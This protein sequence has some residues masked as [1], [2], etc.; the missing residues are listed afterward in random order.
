[1]E[2]EQQNNRLSNERIFTTSRVWE[3][4]KELW[5]LAGP[6]IV[7][8]VSQY[9]LE[10][11]TAAYVGHLGTLELAAVSIVQNVIKGFVYGL[12]LGMGSALETLCGQAVGAGQFNMLGIYMQRSWIITLTTALLLTPVY[13]FTSPILKLLRQDKHISELAGK[14]A[15][16]SIP[17][18]FG[19]ALNF[20]I[21]KFLQSQS[22][23][24]VTTI[25]L[26]SVLGVHAL[27][28]WVVVMRFSH[29]LLGAAM[30]GNLSWFLLIFGQLI[31]IMSGFFPGSWTGFSLLAFS[32]KSF[33]K[34]TLA[35]AIM[36]CLELWYFTIIILMVGWLK[37]PEVAVDAVSTCMNLDVWTLMIALGFNAAVSVRVSNE[38]GAGHP[39]VAKFA[40]LMAISTSAIIGTIFT[41]MIIAL[42][43]QFPKLFS[44]KPPVIYEA[45]KLG[46]LL[47]ATIF[48][49]S[50]QIV[51]QGVAVGAG[52]QSLVAFI[53]T[54]CYYLVGLPVC[55]LLGY[56]F[57]LGAHGLWA[58]LLIG[59][60]LQTAILL[61]IAWRTNWN[62]EA[63]Q[64]K[65]RMRAWGGSTDSMST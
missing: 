48:V 15:L 39:K 57:K 2:L 7:T 6:T 21:Q 34:L 62:K 10:F 64:A 9:S 35:S 43:D 17:Q 12:M 26:L 22:K 23:V 1:M 61:L 36:L 59:V 28:N 3:E 13:I 55:V 65:K 11:V 58:G 45:S 51:L 31:Y 19:Y 32:L 50:I 52:W 20:P 60:L 5:K 29:G 63:S 38:L 49:N 37:D 4:S 33:I 44:D 41:V 47:A 30:V 54:G 40:V 14:Y 24:R 42:K 27:L 25:M 16:W 46:Y 8:A 56:K 18:M 53:T